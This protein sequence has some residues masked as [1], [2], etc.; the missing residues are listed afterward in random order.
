M[1]TAQL[2]RSVYARPDAPQRNPRAVEYDLFAR[3]TRALSDAWAAREADHPA[4]VRALHDN[5]R[6][7][8]TLAGDLAEPGNGLPA[9]LKA[10]LF[11]LHEFSEAHGRKVLAGTGD[12]A[13]LVEINTAVMRGLRGEGAAS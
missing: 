8:R 12:A 13:V 11:W 10:R 5:G 6:L 2:A 1:N 9:E 7:W 3:I 4:L